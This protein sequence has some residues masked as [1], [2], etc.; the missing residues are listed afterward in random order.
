[1]QIERVASQSH[2]LPSELHKRV[3]QILLTFNFLAASKIMNV[4]ILERDVPVWNSLPRNVSKLEPKP[5]QFKSKVKEVYHFTTR[6]DP[7]PK[8]DM[9]W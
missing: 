3:S 4:S 6:M 8:Y 9:N 1:M 5:Q 2:L 7:A